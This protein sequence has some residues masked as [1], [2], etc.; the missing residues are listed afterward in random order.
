MSSSQETKRP[1]RNKR[2]GVAEMAGGGWAA[3]PLTGEFRV[4]VGYASQE[5]LVTDKD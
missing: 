4:E 3:Q 1:K 2:P 5:D